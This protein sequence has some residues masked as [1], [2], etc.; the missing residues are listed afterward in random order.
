MARG[1]VLGSK[2]KRETFICEECGVEHIN[3]VGKCSSCQS[4]NTVKPIRLAKYSSKPL[5]I[6]NSQFASSSDH[7][8]SKDRWL[9]RLNDDTELTLQPMS[10]IDINRAT[11]RISAWSEELNRVLGGG[12]VRG[13][14]L[15]L[16]GEPGVG[17]RFYW[18]NK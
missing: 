13:S 9:P 14:I 17:K 12:L 15:L 1:K 4:W 3:F 11:K 18:E 6:R 16:A 7:G 10:D 5:D 2:E 8:N